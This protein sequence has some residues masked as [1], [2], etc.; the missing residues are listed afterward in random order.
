MNQGIELLVAEFAKPKI[1]KLQLLKGVSKIIKDLASFS[2]LSL[3]ANVIDTISAIKLDDKPGTVGWKLI[4]RSLVDALF[5]L[6]AETDNRFIS[7]EIETAVLDHKLNLFLEER[8]YFISKKF[9][10]EPDKFA[11]IHDIKP[12]LDQYLQLFD[13]KECDRINLLSR[14][15]RYFLHSLIQEWR[16]NLRS[17]AVLQEMLETPFDK[18]EERL[19]EWEVYG[20]YLTTQIHKP[21]F[22]ESFSLAQIYIPLRAEY[23]VFKE[24]KSNEQYGLNTA[25][26]TYERNVVDLE[27][28]LVNWLE[29]GDKKDAIRIIRGGPGVGKSSFL[30]MLSARLVQNGKRVLFIPLH[31]LNSLEG[32]LDETVNSFLR[33]GQFFTHN[34]INQDKDPLILIFDGLDEL[35]RQDEALFD[36]AK[37][38]F[39]EVKRD[40]ESFNIEKL[41]LQ[42]IVSGRDIIVQD[43][44]SE[45]RQE[46]QLL[47][48]LPYFIPNEEQKEL[49]GGERLIREDQRDLWW[50]NY[51]KLKG[52]S[53]EELLYKLKTEDLGEI[54]VQPLLNFLVA[55]SNDHKE[56]DF[57]KKTNL[58]DLYAHLLNAVYERNYAEGRHRTV[59]NIEESEFNLVLQ[60]IGIAAW[61]GAGRTTTV[62]EIRKR[63][64]TNAHLR[65]LAKFIGD[66]EKGVVS[67]LASFYFRRASRTEEGMESF[68][69]THKSF[70]EYLAAMKIVRE[71]L[72]I[73]QNYKDGKMHF[74]EHSGND[75]VSCLKDW[76]NLFGPRVLDRDL[77]RFIRKELA[78]MH[79]DRPE[80]LLEMQKAIIDFIGYMFIQ[81]MPL[82]SLNINKTFKTQNESSINAEK[83]LLVIHGL[84]GHLTRQVFP[85]SFSED[86][87]F[88]SWLYRLIGQ[89]GTKEP[90]VLDFLNSLNCSEA[91][92]VL[93]DLSGANLNKS[94]LIGANLNQADLSGANLSQ[95]DLSKARLSRAHLVRAD[96]SGAD[97]SGA[98][99]S[100]ADLS[101]ADLTGASLRGADLRKAYLSSAKLID[102][103]L[104][105]ANLIGANL[106]DADL[107][108]A[109]LVTAQLSEACMEC[110]DLRDANLSGA[111]L[112]GADLS[113]A[114]LCEANLNRV[115]L[116][117]ADLSRAKLSKA[118]LREADL[119]GSAL[120]GSD[121]IRTNLSGSDLIG[122]KLIGADLSGANLFEAN[123]IGADLRETNMKRTIVQGAQW[124]EDIL[125]QLIKEGRI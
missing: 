98:D 16:G 103:D 115:D 5:V 60:E 30:K 15:E 114:N 87:I 52:K 34:P 10:K 22:S 64:N 80:L 120:I 33:Y 69:F 107:R 14:F 124:S 89:R 21:V 27:T 13:F 109:K 7:D 99:L 111:I 36:V 106:R 19:S 51:G 113:R 3:P 116:S 85:L 31:R 32:K 91:R 118:D 17:Y 46:G 117:R 101:G 100:G 121:L 63:F 47:K 112:I 94:K 54:T 102:T 119:S 84:L 25:E 49:T 65:L 122:T 8:T 68:E 81:G 76:T 73:C 71:S 56:F 40:V 4:S 92:L 96:L 24:K 6:I 26:F 67:L 78:K 35:T 108:K 57:S 12:V 9:L 59:G 110:I 11:L 83:A 29:K 123:L 50:S 95:T 55:I 43:N 48:L 66:A 74:S 39:Y 77:V 62:K 42:I 82:E 86:T 104:C 93:F 88:G 23:K 70:G 37:R 18:A 72:L 28:F 105:E 20:N 53:Y 44:E 2:Y 38:F 58:N 125:D 45:F 41:K 97:L 1:E 79:N 75:L 90:M 61:H